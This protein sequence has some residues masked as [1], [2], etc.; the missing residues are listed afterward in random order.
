LHPLPHG[1]D[2]KQVTLVNGN[3]ND[4]WAVGGRFGYQNVAFHWD[5]ASW[6]S[7]PTPQGGDG[8]SNELNGVWALAPNDVW[9]VG[10][11]GLLLHWDGASFSSFPS[12]VTSN[13]MAVWGS[14]PTSVWAGTQSGTSGGEIVKFDGGTWTTARSP[15][16]VS[17]IHGTGP[18]DMW[19]GG[20]GGSI[21]HWD[22][23]AF[24]S[25]FFPGST[26]VGG[27]WSAGRC[28]AFAASFG[29]YRWLGSS[30]AN[31]FSGAGGPGISGSSPNNVWT[32]GSPTML[33]WNGSTWSPVD[34]SSTSFL[35]GISVGQQG[36]WA[37]G[38]N[39]TTVTSTGG[40]PTTFSKFVVPT[41]SVISDIYV[42]SATQA[43]A[44]SS[45]S[46]VLRWNGSTWTATQVG[47]TQ[48]LSVHGTS[49]SDVWVVG[50]A[51]NSAHFDGSTWSSKNTFT[52]ANLNRVLAFG[53]NDV[54]AVGTGV[55]LH[56]TG[57]WQTI[58]NPVSVGTDLKDV[59][60]TSSSLW[61]AGSGKVIAY[62]G[63]SWSLMPIPSG[64]TV[65]AVWGSAQNSI[66]FPTR[67]GTAVYFNGSQF[68]TLTGWPLG[69]TR[70]WGTSATDLWATASSGSG[71]YHFDGTSWSMED[72]G[73]SNSLMSL[74]GGGGKLWVVGASSAILVH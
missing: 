23:A 51:G 72:I 46:A 4:A 2:L 47:N 11:K 59:W 26:T 12:P 62:N 64:Q 74:T 30:W 24:R 66:W 54:W 39:G 68:T 31:G 14:S 67:N 21:L 35:W 19:I 15:F 53:A 73:N 33:Q 18:D 27:V 61:A 37:V 50:L 10:S 52:A 69:I 13:Y 45:N 58:S 28:E 57:S 70:L 22:G 60:G 42:V 20:A 55:T 71:L 65:A 9:A 36:F 17:A 6:R 41:G 63:S 49:A 56:Y 8:G 40:A 25:G 44:V 48:W 5:G 43:F 1:N 34:S 29:G 3:F 7:V 16:S 38:Q 32:T